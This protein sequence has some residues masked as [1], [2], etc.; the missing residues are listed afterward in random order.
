MLFEKPA[1]FLQGRP[2]IG[3]RIVAQALD[4]GGESVMVFH[5][6]LDYRCRF[7]DVLA[8]GENLFLFHGKMTAEVLI[9]KGH[10]V[11]RLHKRLV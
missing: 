8:Q 7:R 11:L 4:R 9:E 1:E 2:P 10:N 3:W 5:E 6:L